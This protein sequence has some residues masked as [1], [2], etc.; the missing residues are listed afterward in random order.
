MKI[1][2]SGRIT[3]RVEQARTDF[4]YAEQK[5][6]KLGHYPLNPFNFKDDHDKSWNEYM[7]VCIKE[8][9]DCDAIL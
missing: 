1:Y 8:L 9:V 5:L 7:K 6:K 3:G 2:I 4:A